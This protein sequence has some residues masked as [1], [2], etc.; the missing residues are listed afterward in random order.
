MSRLLFRVSICLVALCFF[1]AA[2]P[3]RAGEA[4]DEEAIAAR[5]KKARDEREAAK[6]GKKAPD[7]ADSG[8]SPFGVDNDP[9]AAIDLSKLTGK[10]DTPPSAKPNEAMVP[11][12]AP[13]KNTGPAKPFGTATKP[14]EPANASAALC[15]LCKG[16]TILPLL[17]YKPYAKY[18]GQSA[19]SP[20]FPAQWKWCDKCQKGANPK[21]IIE[22][23]KERQARIPDKH[24][25]FEEFAGKPLKQ[26]ETPFVSVHSQLTP[27]VNATVGKALEKCVGILQ[28]NSHSMVLMTIRPDTDDIV[29]LADPTTYTTYIDKAFARNEA[30]NRELLKKGS[31]ASAIHHDMFKMVANGPPA[32]CCAVFGLGGLIISSA[33][34]GKLKPWLNE[35]FS[36]YCEN[37]TMG[38]NYIYRFNYELNQVKF[39]KNW[40]EDM[41][42]CFKDNKLK[43][44]VEIFQVDMS[45]MKSFEYL[46]CYSI[47]SFL[48]RNDP[49]RFDNFVLNVRN[50]DDTIPAIEKA[51]GMKIKDLQTGWVQWVQT[52]K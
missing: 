9:D 28:N 42:K 47:V 48:I 30:S 46:T 49:V 11:P 33:T 14:G 35:G 15:P 44:W 23:M 51:Y 16:A 3:L 24:K 39:G 4:E 36:A 12:N 41:K 45:H 34:D 7:P 5:E 2:I 40:N 13:G 21:A 18:E 22:D 31:G 52:Q 6:K 50:G 19:P 25:Q 20:D 8:K 10:K 37:A 32:E 29:M 38:T 1:V 27:G 43:P 17:P 26:F